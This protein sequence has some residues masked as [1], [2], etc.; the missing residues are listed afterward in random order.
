MSPEWF[1]VDLPAP[2]ETQ[3]R[4]FTDAAQEGG[5]RE[6]YPLGCG[7]RVHA[8][9]I[10]RW[11]SSIRSSSRPHAFAHPIPRFT[12]VQRSSTERLR[13][14]DVQMVQ[15]RDSRWGTTRPPDDGAKPQAIDQREAIMLVVMRIKLGR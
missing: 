10:P 14:L 9:A 12:L 8:R 2:Y 6:Q 1:G 11:L 5:L 15:I 4:L 7:L 3:E 13:G